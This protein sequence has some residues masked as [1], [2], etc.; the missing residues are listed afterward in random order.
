VDKEKLKATIAAL[1][2]RG[3]TPIAHSLEQLPTDFANVPGDKT[4]VL[5]TDGREEAGGDPVAVV[6]DLLARGFKFKLNVVGFALGDRES[7]QQMQTI[8]EMTGGKFYDAASAAGLRDAVERSVV[9]DTL[10][11]PFSLL[12]A[13]GTEV[14][15][16][17][18]GNKALAAPEGIFTL[19]VQ[20]TPDLTTVPH[21]RITARQP[22]RI[23]LAK[24]GDSF[25]T[26]VE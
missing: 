17:T 9:E 22:T 26:R 11:L 18:T 4:V 5:V 10:A 6:T 25:T 20:T 7:K 8:A 15:I 16:G 3:T 2:T 1:P 13:S 21:V 19:R 23:Q 24:E 14:A 12:D